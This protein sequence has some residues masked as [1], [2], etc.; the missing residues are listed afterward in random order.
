[1]KKRI[2]S[3][4][5]I[6]VALVLTI[7][8][9]Q[10]QTF[11][12]SALSVFRVG[13]AKTITITMDDIAEMSGL[14]KEYIPSGLEKPEG[15]TNG[16]EKVFIEKPDYKTL[17]DASEFTAFNVNLPRKL[18]DQKPELFATDV[19]DKSIEMPD[20]ESISISLSPSL[21]AKYENVVFMATQGLNSDV[22]RE[23]KDE[24]WQK[25]LSVPVL[26]DNIRS[27]LAAIDPDTKDIYLP[28]IT[29]ISR[30]ANLGGSTG[31]LYATSDMQSIMGALPPELTAGVSDKMS[32]AMTTKETPSERKNMNMIIWTKSGVLYVLAG[33]LLDSELVAIARSVR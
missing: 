16:T 27:Q 28:V 23:S 15:Y 7:T 14:A 22:S 33:D 1:M 17:S 11:A 18:N 32:E 29:G 19:M 10:V 26:T 25:L 8:I 5:A 4:G 24:M 30:E 9:P 31:Y 20:G 3:A 2:I 21:F 12:F 6:A 13:D